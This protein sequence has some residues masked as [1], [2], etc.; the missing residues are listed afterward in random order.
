MAWLSISSALVFLLFYISV[1]NAPVGER[2]MRADPLA[3]LLPAR[4]LLSPS[5]EEQAG[6]AL[7]R[8]GDAARRG[9]V[10]SA[11][12][13]WHPEGVIVDTNF[14]PA[15][16]ADD[17]V[18][19]GTAELKQRYHDEFRQR[20]YRQLKHNNL[21]I[22][23]DGDEV[24]IVNDLHAVIEQ[25]ESVQRVELPATDRW[26]LRKVDSEWKIVRLELNRAPRAEE[27]IEAFR[28]QGQ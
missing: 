23:A 20:L 3:Q 17:R 28:L 6:A 10:A 26:V 9:D 16:K 25:G 22:R 1:I 2:L 7:V 18:W 13:L 15:V 24:V 4:T 8:E 12:A 14:T 11:L 21:R 19:R 27:F 5:P